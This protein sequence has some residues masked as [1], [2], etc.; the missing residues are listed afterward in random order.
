MVFMPSPALLWIALNGGALPAQTSSPSTQPFAPVAAPAPDAAPG[1]Q[2]ADTYSELPEVTVTG[3]ATATASDPFAAS[4]DIDVLAGEA[5]RRRQR[6][7]LGQ[8]LEHLPGVSN[9]AT[10]PQAGKPVI[11]GLSGNRI[12]VLEDGIATNFQQF[13]IRH[14]PNIDPYMAQ[15]IEVVRGAS[16]VL[17]GSDALGGAVNVIPHKPQYAEQGAWRF[18]GR[19]T[20]RYATGNDQFTGALS[21]DVARGNVGLAGDLVYRNAGNLEVPDQRTFVQGDTSGTAPGFSGELPFTD[22]NQL[23]GNLALGLQGDAGELTLRHTRYRNE[24]NFL[25][26]PPPFPGGGGPDPGPPGIDGLGQ[27]LANDVYQLKADLEFNDTW[28]IRPSLT[29]ARNERRAAGRGDTLPID[30]PPIDVERDNYTARVELHHENDASPLAGTLGLEGVREEQISDGVVGLTPG[31]NVN[32]FAAFAFEELDLDPLVLEAGVRFDYRQQKASPGETRDRSL[33]DRDGDGTIDVDL[34]NTY[35]SVTGSLGAMYRFTDQLALAGN[36]GRGFRAPDLFELYVNGV[37]GGVAAVQL[38]DPDLAQETSLT[39]DLSLRWRSDRV[40]GKVT[41]YRNAIDNFIFPAGTGA[42]QG[43]LPVF[44]LTQQDAVLHGGDI[45]FEAD[46][47]DWLAIRAVYEVV[48]GELTESND[49]VPSLPADRLTLETKLTQKNLGPLQNPYLSFRVE[50]AFNKESA[51]LKEPFGQFDNTP[52]GT[53]STDAYTL[54]DV[55]VGFEYEQVEFSVQVQNVLDEPYR[56]F[57][58]TYKGYALSPGRSVVL[59]VSAPF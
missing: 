57:L 3:T 19:A 39:T 1:T 6:T 37:H 18:G 26:P 10:G 36:I 51:G 15:R 27:R 34:D 11:R 28:S 35:R 2:P 22:F 55:G 29:Y 41:V 45:S 50:H 23:N 30:D 24:Q 47:L 5:K 21:L 48:R 4:S 58:D 38:G 52:F 40:R 17:Y 8:S 12:R 46:V 56:D 59:T 9:I 42:M 25:L 16:S 13:G 31:G 7:S 44:Q 43:G 14:P 32:N 49:D 33:L 53:A 20:T 54:L